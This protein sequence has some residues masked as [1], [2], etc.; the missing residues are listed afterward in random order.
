[1]P[2]ELWMIVAEFLAGEHKL[3]SLASL[4]VSTRTLHESTSA[5][6]W[7]TVTLDTFTPRWNDMLKKLLSSD[8][9]QGPLPSGKEALETAMKEFERLKDQPVALPENRRHVK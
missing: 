2:S 5:V 3:G 8:D 9:A 7:T 4:N 6:L 1:M